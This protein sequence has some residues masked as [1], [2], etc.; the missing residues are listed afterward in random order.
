MEGLGAE[1]SAKIRSAIKAKL[2]ELEAYV[3]DELPDYIMVMVANKRTKEQ[4]E[5]D[6]GLFLNNNTTAF[7]NW[8]HAVLEKLQ[9]VT[10]GEVTKKKDAKKKKTP[11]DSTNKKPKDG[12]KDRDSDIKRT[13]SPRKE[14][15]ASRSRSSRGREKPKQGSSST[16]KSIPQ[17]VPKSKKGV[18]N[19]NVAALGKRKTA[20]KPEDLSSAAALSSGGAGNYDPA[21]LL[22][23]AVA[24]TKE[25]SKTKTTSTKKSSSPALKKVQSSVKKSPT[26]KT[27]TKKDSSRKTKSSKKS[28]ADIF[29]SENGKDDDDHDGVEIGLSKEDKADPMF[30]VKESEER[31]DRDAKKI[32]NLKADSEFYGVKG[33]EKDELGFK[34]KRRGEM[35]RQG[36]SSMERKQSRRKETRSRSRSRS[37]DKG[38][39]ALASTVVRPS[40]HDDSDEEYDAEKIL[41]SS[42]ASRAL[43][44]PRPARPVGREERGSARAVSRAV[45]AA[46]RSIMTNRRRPEVGRGRDHR[47][48]DDRGRDRDDR[49]RDG[50]RG[51]EEGRREWDEGRKRRDIP[52]LSPDD[53]EKYEALKA[54]VSVKS[55]VGLRKREEGARIRRDSG[56]ENRRSFPER[57]LAMDDELEKMG[58]RSSLDRQLE[59]RRRTSKEDLARGRRKSPEVQMRRR[60]PEPEL[61]RKRN[62]DEDVRIIVRRDISPEVP[63]KKRILEETSRRNEER[64]MEEDD[65]DLME[66]RRK[67]LESLMKKRDR[68]IERG[69]RKII[70][71]LGNDSSSDSD[72]STTSKQE[73][74]VSLSDV[75][76]LQAKSRELERRIKKHQGRS[77]ETEISRERRQNRDRE[78]QKQEERR[79]VRHEDEDR[80]DGEKEPTFVVTLDG[81]DEKYFKKSAGPLNAP[82]PLKRAESPVGE[83]KNS[84][85][86]KNEIDQ[87]DSDQEL[88][89][90]PNENF[91]EP[92]VDV[93]KKEAAAKKKSVKKNSK[94]ID[95]SHDRKMTETKEPKDKSSPKLTEAKRPILV[96]PVAP[97]TGRKRSP[98]RPPTTTTNSNNS[99]LINGKEKKIAAVKP[100]MATVPVKVREAQQTTKPKD[101]SDGVTKP[102]RTPITAPE[103]DNRPVTSLK[104][105]PFS[106]TMSYSGNPYPNT[107]PAALQTRSGETCAYWPNC[108]RGSS[109]MFYHPPVSPESSLSGSKYKWTAS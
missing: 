29:M 73:S 4:M 93:K 97:V 96:K 23:K 31:E 24:T 25:T 56:P 38:R 57:R 14:S 22:K 61:R 94:M 46:D 28:A 81:I 85:D 84:N 48:R 21:S 71:P 72:S 54:R 11:K 95:K 34:I 50:R 103:P 67:A 37:W 86:K 105:K 100:S 58:R 52:R 42:L 5:D 107:A 6:L 63:K 88:V 43:V 55:S 64:R 32:I 33:G 92:E 66:M 75:E 59:G 91:D 13:R 83:T 101:V 40:R 30:D 62:I 49:V 70:I 44:P 60:S 2:I 8:L 39:S 82:L 19:A 1:V 36:S 41:K 74:E 47:D 98:I 108:V 10:L 12:T 3:D 87:E 65:A 51:R 69:E 78:R 35:S 68:E 106:R 99:S 79:Q 16:D 80:S 9:K 18:E 53:I 77:P 17:G 90:H 26:K 45:A 109:C 89:L 104:L 20:K 7:T 76:E 15:S 102:K 27:P